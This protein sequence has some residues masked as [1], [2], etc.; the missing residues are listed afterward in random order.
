V[1]SNEVESF[2]LTKISR[3]LRVA[4]REVIQIG[5]WIRVMSIMESLQRSPRNVPSDGVTNAATSRGVQSAKALDE[6]WSHTSRFKKSFLSS[7]ARPAVQTSLAINRPCAAGI[8]VVSLDRRTPA[9]EKKGEG[10][11]RTG[12]PPETISAIGSSSQSG[13]V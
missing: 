13:R 11:P 9:N 6:K 12:R 5:I 4:T 8:D 10:R 1:D 7:L 3:T 2:L